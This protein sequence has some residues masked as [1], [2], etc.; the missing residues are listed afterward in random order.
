MSTHLRPLRCPLSSGRSDV[1][2]SQAATLV[3]GMHMNKALCY[4]KIEAWDKGVQAVNKALEF[5]GDEGKC[6]YR[7]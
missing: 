3:K 7:R 6:M 2:S 1:H 4:T 5:G